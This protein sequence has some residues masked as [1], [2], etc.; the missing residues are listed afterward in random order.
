MH[1]LP[2][3][4]VCLTLLWV[5]ALSWLLEASEPVLIRDCISI[6][7]ALRESTQC[8]DDSRVATTQRRLALA[9]LMSGI[10]SQRWICLKNAVFRSGFA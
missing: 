9:F 4:L 6:A 10:G 2:R 3:L 7:L 8:V 5:H 1:V